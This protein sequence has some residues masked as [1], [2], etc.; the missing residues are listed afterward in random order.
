MP[1]A[2]ITEY[3]DLHRIKYQRI[4]HSPAYTAQEVAARAHVSGWDLAKTVVVKLDD[5]LVMAVLPASEQIDLGFLAEIVGSKRVSLAHEEDFVDRFPG[6]DLGAIPPFG[7]LYGLKVYVAPELA[8]DDYIFFSAGTH[9]E[10][11]RMAYDDFEWLVE[12]E[13]LPFAVLS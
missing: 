8:E 7:N 9:T 4:S 11:I 3:L 13:M 5:E 2:R 10:L 6:C 12:P 1:I